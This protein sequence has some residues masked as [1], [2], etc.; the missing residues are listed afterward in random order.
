MAA[1]NTQFS[2]AIH[3]M[4]GLGIDPNE[5]C[6]STELSTSVN[7]NPSFVRRVLAKLAKAGLVN[8][9]TGKTGC[10]SIARS[11]KSISL[12][13][14]YE[15]V[16]A[17]KVFAIHQYPVTKDCRVSTCIKPAMEN[18]LNKAQK[19]LEQSLKGVYL[20]DVIADVKKLKKD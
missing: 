15:A 7:A 16:E 1:V 18:V 14:I 19:S 13:E 20:S 8:A 12:L 11:A 2:I 5:R 17:P 3:I 10:C 9:T 6:T 4:A